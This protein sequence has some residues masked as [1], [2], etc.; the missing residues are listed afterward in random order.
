LIK[1]FREPQDRAFVF[2]EIHASAWMRD[3]TLGITVA[4]FA[5]QQGKGML[6]MIARGLD[7]L[8]QDASALFLGRLAVTFA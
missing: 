1:E 7:K 5:A 8:I 4:A 2:G 6:A 3:G